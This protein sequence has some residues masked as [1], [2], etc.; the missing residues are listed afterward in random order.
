[1]LDTPTHGVKAVVGRTY[2]YRVVRP[3]VTRPGSE[4]ATVY[5]PDGRI[6]V[7]K[8]LP[9]A[10]ATDAVA[11]AKFRAEAKIAAQLDHPGIVKTLEVVETESEDFY[12]M[13]YVRGADMRRLMDT[14]AAQRRTLPLD[15]VLL[16]GIELG[17][18]LDYAH[19]LVEPVIHRE[20]SPSKVLIGH[21]GRIKLTGFA[22]P[23]VAR[24][25]MRR[26]RSES[27]GY[28]SPERFVGETQDAR[29]DV[30]ALGVLIY[31]L[32]SGERLFGDAASDH[33]IMQKVLRGE[34]P[35]PSEVRR[36][37]PRELETILMRALARDRNERYP[38]AAALLADLETFL[39]SRWP[40][41]TT[42]ALAKLVGDEFAWDDVPD[43]TIAE[44]LDSWVGPSPLATTFPHGEPTPLP[45]RETKTPTVPAR[46]PR[47]SVHVLRGASPPIPP[48]RP[49]SELAP[50]SAHPVYFDDMATIARPRAAVATAEQP[51]TAAP[52]PPPR[53]RTWGW[54]GS[55]GPWLVAGITGTVIGMVAAYAVRT[56]RHQP[57]AALSV[58]LAEPVPALHVVAPEVLGTI[59]VPSPRDLEPPKAAGVVRSERT[60]PRV[61]RKAEPVKPK[62]SLFPPPDRLPVPQAAGTLDGLPSIKAIDLDGGIA[63]IGVRKSVEQTLSPLRGCYRAAARAKQQTPRVQLTIAFEVGERRVASKIRT[64][65]GAP[66]DNL[67]TCAAK[68][69][70]DIR[71]LPAPEGAGARVIV[72]VEFRP[73]PPSP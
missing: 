13:E 73:N 3:L 48:P 24:T 30:F 22:A 2:R 56:T 38:T 12:T 41:A 5:T 45:P 63:L 71:D 46:F 44:P 7:M 9:P 14:L 19:T 32:S 69:A 36:G 6:A 72:S 11:V 37:Y 66:L 39:W 60:R 23:P 20:L 40:T 51:P 64:T 26:S 18:A 65:G 61:A 54:W 68:V 21:D 55:R 28:T 34:V 70:A 16:I 59:D 25:S 33:E 57:A 4:F 58:A 53:R 52:P 15:C 47:S 43:T 35:R 50:A 29:S 67:A 62:R 8:R 1:M 27:L 42:A 31:E 49:T 10:L 17:N